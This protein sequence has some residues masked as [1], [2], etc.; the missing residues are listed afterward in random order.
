MTAQNSFS[1]EGQ[2]TW[3]II[4]DVALIAEVPFEVVKEITGNVREREANDGDANRHCPEAPL[5]PRESAGSTPCERENNAD[6]RCD[7]PR[8]YNRPCKAPLWT[9]NALKDATADK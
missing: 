5:Q 3:S 9:K 8:K 1:P 4:R 7:W 2:M 6:D